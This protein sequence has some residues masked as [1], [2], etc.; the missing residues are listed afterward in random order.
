MSKRLKAGIGKMHEKI[1]H[2]TKVSKKRKTTE[3]KL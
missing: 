2:K 1:L 3:N